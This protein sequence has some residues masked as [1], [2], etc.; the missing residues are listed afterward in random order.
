MRQEDGQ[1]KGKIKDLLIYRMIH[2]DLGFNYQLLT[3]YDYNSDLKGC[4]EEG[5]MPR[6]GV[7]TDGAKSEPC[8]AGAS[9]CAIKNLPGS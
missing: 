3:P 6:V 7:K 8:H 5:I 9:Y 4:Y 2:M 1:Q